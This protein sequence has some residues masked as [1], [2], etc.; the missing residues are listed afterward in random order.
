MSLSRLARAVAR[1]AHSAPL[2]LAMVAWAHPS[3]AQTCNPAT[4]P[5]GAHL[6]HARDNRAHVA[7]ACTECHPAVCTASPGGSVVFGALASKDGAAPAW[8]ATARTCSGVYCHGATL[9]A[10]T[11]PVAWTYVD[12]SV[13][14]PPAV[15]CAMCHGYPPPPSHPQ[16][17]N[18]RGCHPQTVLADGSIDLAGGHHIDGVLDVSGG[19]GGFG[20]AACHGFPPTT[21]AHV[22]HFG[23][24]GAESS[25][26]YADVRTLQDRYPSATPT[27]APAVYA[28]G[29]ALCHSVDGNRHMNGTVDVALFEAAAPA[30]SLKARASTTAS[31]NPATKTCSGAYCHSTGQAGPTFK[32]TPGWFSGQKVGCAGCHDNPPAYPSGGP[33]T[34]TAN[35]HLGL[36]DDGYEFGHFLGMPGPFHTS[37]HGG[38]AWGPTE[39]AT[40]I[41][42]QTCH[43]DTTD[44]ANT[45]PSGFYYLDTSGSYALGTVDPGWQAQQQCGYCHK[46]GGAATGTGKV[47]PLRHVNGARDV[48]FDSR[49]TLPSIGW[50]P[51]APNTPT[52]P[53]WMTDASRSMPYPS[54]VTWNGSTV[55]F[56][57]GTSSYNPATKTC[58]SVACHLVDAPVWGRPYEYFTNG[59]P[60]CVRCHPM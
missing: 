31:Y 18:C 52:A 17:S 60:T 49:T 4:S 21:G 40:A 57:L 8:N 10:P 7:F 24:T 22:A 48:V 20:C 37:K 42:C 46:P 51:A 41:T 45:G 23:L 14:K 26:S 54:F 28:F 19:T 25:G 39:D 12:V 36:G 55:S 50:L 3:A 56:G 30:G 38:G 2:L 5:L 58:S 43:Y 53:Y 16:V 32:V 15:E 35:S 29:C 27:T 59:G 13:P 9:A 44:P 34:A 6:S 11:G 47:L 1:P 33:A